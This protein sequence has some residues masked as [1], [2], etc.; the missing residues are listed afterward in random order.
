MITLEYGKFIKN[1]VRVKSEKT[2][3]LVRVDHSNWRGY[4]KDDVNQVIPQIDETYLNN[5]EKY[6]HDLRKNEDLM[7]QYT[8]WNHFL[9]QLNHIDEKDIKRYDLPENFIILKS[10]IKTKDKSGKDS[11]R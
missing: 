6:L 10:N 1:F 9:Y 7:S 2:G 4:S 3:N 8:D 5:W 11:N